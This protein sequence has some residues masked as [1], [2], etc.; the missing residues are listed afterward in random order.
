MRLKPNFL[1]NSTF[2]I[3]LGRSMDILLLCGLTLPEPMQRQSASIKTWLSLVEVPCAF[4]AQ[5]HQ[6]DLTPQKATFYYDAK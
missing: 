2:L 1:E 4:N 6:T 3:D 5:M